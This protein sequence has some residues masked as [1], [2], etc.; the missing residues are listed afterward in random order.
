MQMSHIAAV[1]DSLMLFFLLSTDTGKVYNS[2]KDVLHAVCTN[3]IQSRK[4]VQYFTAVCAKFYRMADN[5]LLF[6]VAVPNFDNQKIRKPIKMKREKRPLCHTK[7][8]GGC[9]SK[10]RFTGQDIFIREKEKGEL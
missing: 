10:H 1:I 5:C 8:K 9:F 6:Q 3:V 2:L 7:R 4:C